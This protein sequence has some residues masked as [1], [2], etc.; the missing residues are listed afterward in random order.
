MSWKWN[1][2]TILG[3]AI[4]VLGIIRIP[5]VLNNSGGGSYGIGQ[6]TGVILVSLVGVWLMRSGL[7]QVRN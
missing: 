3:A 5:Q 4:L 6:V 2:K 1:W 7:S